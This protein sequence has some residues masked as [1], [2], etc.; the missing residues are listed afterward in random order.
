MKELKYFLL[1]F[2]TTSFLCSFAQ[3]GFTEISKEAGINHA[4]VIDQATF[5]GGAA[6][7]DYDNDGYEDIYITGG[8]LSDVLYRNNGNGTFSN[9]FSNRGLDRT[10]EVY[11]QGVT[12]A[13][14]NRDGYKDLLV[15][16]MNY[17]TPERNSAPNLLFINQKD[18]TFRDETKEWGLENFRNN[19]TGA[20]FGDINMDGYPDLY[21]SNYYSSSPIG[22]SIYNE[23]TITNSFVP[24]VDYLYINTGGNSFLEVSDAYNMDHDGFGFQGVFTDYDNDLDLDLYIANDF[25]FKKT[26]NRMYRNDFPLN[27]FKERSLNLRLNY[28][29]NAVGIAVADVNLDG[30]MDYFTT[31]LSTSVLVYNQKDGKGF[32]DQTVQAGVALPTISD[33]LYSGPPISWGANFFDFD[34]DMDSDLFVCNGALNPT[35][36]LNP[37]LFF[38][39]DNGKFAQIAKEVNL[40]DFRI[41]RGSVVFDYDQDGDLDLLVV[42]QAPRS[43][44]DL[45][46]DLLEARCLL[47]RNDASQGNWLQVELKGV[48]SELN[49]LGS[50]IEVTADDVVLIREIQGGSSHLSQNTT[51]AHFGLGN[52]EEV[53]TL[54]VKWLG[55]KSQT[56]NN[57]AVNQKII[58]TEEIE[59]G[60]NPSE[61]QFTVRPAV[62]SDNVTMEFRLNE[63]GSARIDLFDAQGKLV[64][65]LYDQEKGKVA[66]VNKNLPE[67]LASGVYFFRLI[68]NDQVITQ[69]SIKL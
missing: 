3:E 66:I 28:G 19:S 6:I 11:T 61:I 53:E 40:F 7:V 46:G 12:A 26:P 39:N 65:T 18:G 52:L 4:F 45:N 21:V 14:V 16:T 29:M 48:K 32:E 44:T 42:N 60:T 27:K 43:P 59:A 67:S 50:R 63:S 36:R 41:G 22:I 31:N 49:G 35:I 68:A 10:L 25:G 47:Y 69:K 57:I 2:F 38:R 13:D 30:W 51:I 15:T 1:L 55:G 24:S 20:T 64:S 34:H 8:V 17:L 37:N 33:E 9:V 62:I 58:I 23:S 5:G 54:I 56:L